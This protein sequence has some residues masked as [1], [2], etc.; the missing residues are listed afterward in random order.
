MAAFARMAQAVPEH[1]FALYREATLGS[2]EVRGFLAE[3]NPAALAAM[4]ATF[5]EFGFKLRRN[6][7]GEFPA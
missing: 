7:T 1:L 5:A 6:A 2:P 4:E 3:A